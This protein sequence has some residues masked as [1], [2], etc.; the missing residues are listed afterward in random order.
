MGYETKNVEAKHF[1]IEPNTSDRLIV[2][3][4]PLRV[5]AIYTVFSLLVN[6]EKHQTGTLF[7]FS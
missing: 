1:K 2:Q 3:S 5:L 6:K 4:V 7:I